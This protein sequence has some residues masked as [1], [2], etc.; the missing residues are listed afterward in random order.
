MEL[1]LLGTHGGGL[2]VPHRCLMGEVVIVGEEPLLFDCGGGVTRQLPKAGIPAHAVEHLFFTHHHLDHNADYLYFAWSTWLEGRDRDLRVYGP[3]EIARM[4]EMLFGRDG[5]IRQDQAART[6][7]E[8]ARRLFTNRTE[9]QRSWIDVDAKEIQSPGLV[10][11]TDNW[12]V[13]A[14][15]TEHVEPFMKTL[16]YRVDS[17]GGSVAIAADSAPTQAVIDLAQG[18]DI[19]LHECSAKEEFIDEFDLRHHHTWPKAVARV[20]V[21]ANAG[22]LVLTHFFRETDDPTI[23]REM[24]QEVRSI[25]SGEVY[26]GEDLMRVKV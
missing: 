11:E 21:E 17:P 9:G 23:L 20:A 26:V 8:Q 25:F 24:A 16:A 12:K 3:P 22:K 1:V 19:L 10:C 2:Y 14:T 15:V 13:T 4:S 7:G 6:Q 18:V 5:V